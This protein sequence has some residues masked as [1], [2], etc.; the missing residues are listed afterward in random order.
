MPAPFRLVR[1][2]SLLTLA[3]LLVT[4]P[5]VVAAQ[6]LTQGSLQGVILVRGSG[7]VSDAAVTLEDEGGS[8]VRRFRTDRRGSFSIPLLAPGR[9]AVLVEKTGYQPFRQHGVRVLADQQTNL[10][11]AVTRRP[12]P[13]TSVEESAVADQQFV[14]G[15]PRITEALGGREFERDGAR[16]DL[17]ELGRFSTEVVAP[18]TPAW[19]FGDVVGSVP[20]TESRASIDGLPIF[21]LR[22][23][24]VETV[25]AGL[26]LTPPYLVEEARFVTA[27]SDAEIAGGAGGVLSVVTRP[28]SRAV[29]FAPFA[30]FGLSPGLSSTLKQGGSLRN[31]QAGGVLTGTLV[32]DKAQFIVGGDY[33]SLTLPSAAPWTRDSSTMGGAVVPL[34]AAIE[35]VARDSFGVDASATT[36]AH[37]RTYRGGMGM[38]GV[39]WQISP[40]HRL[41]V[42]G[43]GASHTEERPLVGVDLMNGG[44]SSLSSR[45]ALGSVVLTSS[46]TGVSNELHLGVQSATRDWKATGPTATYFVSDEAGI[47]TVP[48][49][50]G[51][52]K[53]TNFH[54]ADAVL[55][56]FGATGENRFK[57]GFTY[58][59]GTWKQDYV[60]GKRGIYQFGDL[61]GFQTATG[62]FSDLVSP[63]TD[64]SFRVRDIGLFTHLQMKVSSS[65]TGLVGL[66]WDRQKFPSTSLVAD[67]TFQREFGISSNRL[68]DDKVNLSPR[69]GLTWTGG[70][71]H[72]WVANFIAAIDHGG[73]NPERFAEAALDG[74]D[75]RIRRSVGGFG[76]WPLPPD[77]IALPPAGRRFALFSPTGK[78]K[79]PRTSKL[80]LE[81]SRRLPSGFSIRVTGRYHH[82]DFLLRR[83]D[84]NLLAAPTGATQEGRAVY[85]TLVQ[86][87]GLVVASPGSNRR[88]GNFDLVSAFSST[89]AQDFYEAS[90]RVARTFGRGFEL[91]AVYSLSRTRDNWLQSWSGDPT[92]ELS[93]F[94]ADPLGKG[95]A[96]GTSDFD[97]PQRAMIV[98]TWR[99]SGP[100][101]L[102][103]SGRFRYQSG[104]PFTPGFQPGVD[105]NG[106]GSG[107]NDPA[108]VDPAIP[109]MPSVVPQ[110]DCLSGQVGGFVRRN[111]C[112]DPGRHALDLAA[113]VGL[114]VRS[115]GGHVELTLDVINL[116]A[117]SAGVMDH[118]LV[119][120][121]PA[122]T[123]VTD[124]SGNVTLPLV[125]N[126]HFGKMLSR[127]DEPRIVRLG[128]RLGN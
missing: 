49:L 116:A 34:S 46:W 118:A 75:L 19:G 5:A 84:L 121:D 16:L 77:T 24:G 71:D 25:P 93:P 114:P 9:Y 83:S 82:T 4:G 110:H 78:Y 109:G 125:A 38:A 97:V 11:I 88:F 105:A 3:V 36:R 40:Q 55:Y 39:D 111:S 113:A 60:Y 51:Y 43:A 8:A 87:G 22:H 59:D 27:A 126:P 76:G 13:I 124:P 66:R 52:F 62:V 122:G 81:I 128:V 74:R 33:E 107:R 108:F 103:V 54:L 58:A 7:P 45:D 127:R 31:A 63:R 65:L 17:S 106:D 28:T 89:A 115:L 30:A 12:P 70:P 64:V 117:S 21:G 86:S 35:G 26:P 1:V 90:L 56:Q 92:D 47:G 112:R 68:P 96:K 123:L 57:V 29:Q 69:F 79:T 32:K 100:V 95:W 67:T 20:Q 120:V 44:G 10:T 15:S 50:P 53:R 101:Q 73:L 102:R 41:T 72:G 61:D 80:D 104:L 99:S 18:R 14:P 48:T 85:G 119:L 37:S 2:R 42:R 91:S 94:P 23:P 98:G 6:S